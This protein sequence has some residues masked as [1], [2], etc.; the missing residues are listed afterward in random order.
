MIEQ[1]VTVD[2]LKIRCLEEGRG[3]AVLLMHGGTLGFSADIWRRNVPP[4]AA[5]GHR[6]IAYDQPGFG[7][8]DAP[9][10]FG[11]R[12]RQAF[13]TRFLDALDVE[14]PALIGHSQAGGIVV[15]AAL[16]TPRRFAGVL[17]L[18]TGSLLPP[19][20]GQ[21]RD[22]D[23]PEREPSR[24]D[25]KALLAANLYNH[26]LITPD[27]L[28]AYHRMSVGRNFTNAVKRAEAASAAKSGSGANPLWQRLG[29]VTIP[30][31]FV[32]GANDRASAAERVKL[33]R[34]RF[35]KLTFHLLERCHH[36]VQW[37]RPDEFLR[38]ATGFLES[39]P[40]FLSPMPSGRI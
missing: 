16:D 12:Y 37:D 13:M 33:A 17:V 19:L 34:E 21:T 11:L 40:S 36:I 1:Y 28:D 3:P 30:L 29:E 18:G 27:V 38:L 35:P 6:V 39:L 24:K 22:V 2:G 7:M 20:A 25:T 9:A 15:G 5:A 8:S 4:L 31:L 26:D 14:R 10:D 23:V 32:Y